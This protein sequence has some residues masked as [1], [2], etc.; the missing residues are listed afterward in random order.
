MVE[1]PAPKITIN[2]ICEYPLFIPGLNLPGDV[3]KLTATLKRPDS[4]KEEPV[5]LAVKPDNTLSVVFVPKYPGEHLIIVKKRKCHVT[6]SPFRMMVVASESTKSHGQLSVILEEFPV[7]YIPRLGP[8]F[9]DRNGNE[10]K[11]VTSVK[12]VHPVGRTCDVMLN[13]LPLSLPR[14]F[15]KLTATIKRPNARKEQPVKLVL[16][17]NNTLGKIW[18]LI[19]SDCLQQLKAL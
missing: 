11:D 18:A 2:N 3:Q 1:D 15:K 6:G 9:D 16:N 4:F 19:K 12:E 14:D 13:I 7:R 10:A 8:G 5:E 17:E